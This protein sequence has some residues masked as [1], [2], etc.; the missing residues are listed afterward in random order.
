M[1]RSNPGRK[2]SKLV[3][4]RINMSK[5]DSIADA[6]TIIRNAIRAKKEETHISFSNLLMQ[7]CTILKNEGYIENFKE[8]EL[9]NFKKIKVYLKYE[10]RKSV[11][12]EIKR[13][14]RPG[15]RVYVE[16]KRIPK[17]LHGH[18]IGIISTSQGILTDLQT[19]QKGIGGEFIG[20]VW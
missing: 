7:I 5:T 4:W 1:A 9:G 18:G 13:V 20:M 6:F 17:V 2:K 10:G 15:R 19:R 14:S 3:N 12:S 16:K 11:L 8:T